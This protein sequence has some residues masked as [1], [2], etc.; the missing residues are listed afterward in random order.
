MAQNKTP[1]V[2]AS[3]QLSSAPSEGEFAFTVRVHGPCKPGSNQPAFMDKLP[4]TESKS[5]Y[6][7]G[8]L[9]SSVRDKYKHNGPV[10]VETGSGTLLQNNPDVLYDR[11]GSPKDAS[12]DPVIVHV[13]LDNEPKKLPEKKKANVASQTE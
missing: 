6:T 5:Q 9:I 3:T 10:R 11:L 12:A 8:D 13:H 1:V 2:D 7:V 4:K